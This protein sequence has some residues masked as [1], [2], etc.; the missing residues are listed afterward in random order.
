MMTKLKTESARTPLGIQRRII[1]VQ[2][3]IV[4]MRRAQ[5]RADTPQAAAHLLKARSS[6]WLRKGGIHDPV[7]ALLTRGRR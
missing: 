6:M 4:H 3:A 7:N 5:G 1:N 2:R